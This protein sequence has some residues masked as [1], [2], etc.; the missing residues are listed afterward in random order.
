MLN[1]QI[2]YHIAVIYKTGTFQIV[3]IYCR[4]Y[5]TYCADYLR[6]HYNGHIKLRGP[7]EIYKHQNINTIKELTN[8]FTKYNIRIILLQFQL[9]THE[10]MI[11]LLFNNVMLGVK[12]MHLLFIN[13]F[14]Q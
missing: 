4:T 13:D 5:T 2:A 8:Y 6:V 11:G 9:T 14:I 10:V 3:K 1:N 12:W 7:C